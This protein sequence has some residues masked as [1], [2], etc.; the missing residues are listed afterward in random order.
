MSLRPS[1]AHTFPLHRTSHHRSFS[2]LVAGVRR[3]LLPSPAPNQ[4]PASAGEA[5][6]PGRKQRAP[7]P[8]ATPTP[9]A[10]RRSIGSALAAVSA[11][12]ILEPRSSPTLL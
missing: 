7:S 3:R 11:G 12:R 2:H 9:L 4:T 8:S 10:S 1:L 6:E 5:P